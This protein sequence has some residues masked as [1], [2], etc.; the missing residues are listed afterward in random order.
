MLFISIN[1]S[2]RRFSKNIQQYFTDEYP[3]HW[4]P[5]V[6]AN[7]KFYRKNVYL[8]LAIILKVQKQ[9]QQKENMCYPCNRLYVHKNK[10]IFLSHV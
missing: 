10:R 3:F 5:L 1:F 7:G 2:R 8:I 9:Q 4:P 6:Q